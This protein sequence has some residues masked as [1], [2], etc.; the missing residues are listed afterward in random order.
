MVLEYWAAQ[1]W[2][3]IKWLVINLT[4]KGV[5]F[6]PFFSVLELQEAG[7]TPGPGGE[8]S[9]LL[10]VGLHGL[11]LA[12]PTTQVLACI[13]VSHFGCSITLAY[14]AENEYLADLCISPGKQACKVKRIH[15][16]IVTT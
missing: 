7:R 5:V 15:C 14:M 8:G 13:I 3:V 6:S 2:L 1:Y 4:P 16:M 12:F 10:G 11:L 9:A